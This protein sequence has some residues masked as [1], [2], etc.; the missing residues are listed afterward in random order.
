VEGGTLRRRRGRS[1]LAGARP[2][3]TCLLARS[4]ETDRGTHARLSPSCRLY[5]AGSACWLRRTR[6]SALFAQLFRSLTCVLCVLFSVLGRDLHRLTG[7]ETPVAMI[8]YKRVGE[9]KFGI[10][11]LA[12]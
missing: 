6:R 1:G 10:E 12:A 3:M 9:T 11:P 4:P 7:P 8:F 2:S 5:E